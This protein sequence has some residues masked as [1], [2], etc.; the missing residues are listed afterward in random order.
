MTPGANATDDD[1]QE[2]SGGFNDDDSK[3]M[4]PYVIRQN[5]RLIH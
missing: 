2:D 4:M 5:V 1:D 3:S